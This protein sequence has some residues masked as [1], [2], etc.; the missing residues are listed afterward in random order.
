MNASMVIRDVAASSG[1]DADK[2]IAGYRGDHPRL[3]AF[4]FLRED[5]GHLNILLTEA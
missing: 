1:P 5:L 3:L 2:L 4:H